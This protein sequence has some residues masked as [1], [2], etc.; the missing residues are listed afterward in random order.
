MNEILQNLMTV[1]DEDHAKAVVEHRAVTIR[2]K[3]T[4]FAAKL[5]AKRL[6]EWGDANEAAEIM[7]ERCWQGF[8]ASWVRD[9]T[10]RVVRQSPSD[11]FGAI[12][13]G[14]YRQ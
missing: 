8:Q 9:R 13:N 12:A 14:T 4:P 10:P 6:S 1:L 5:L 2:K 11:V 3:L 7:I